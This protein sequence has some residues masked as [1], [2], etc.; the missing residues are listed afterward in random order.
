VVPP[1]QACRGCQGLLVI[2]PRTGRL[3]YRA[4]Y[5]W[6]EDYGHFLR[7]GARRIYALRLG[8]FDRKGRGDA[9]LG[10][11]DVAFVN[12]DGS[13]VVIVYNN[14]DAVR[15][16]ELRWHSMSLIR[17]VPAGWAESISWRAS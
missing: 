9:T 1:N 17:T 13:D 5:F 7:E 16:I 14:S 3:T 12:P 8:R 2:D 10:M 6:L 15:Q 4:D 11:H